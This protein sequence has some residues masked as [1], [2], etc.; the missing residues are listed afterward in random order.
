[1]AIYEVRTL[2][3]EPPVTAL[4]QPAR[5]QLSGLVATPTTQE[6]EH[7]AWGTDVP[8][9]IAVTAAVA[10][11]P[12]WQVTV[13]G[14][15]TTPV[16]RSPEGLASFTV[17]PGRHHLDLRFTHTS[18][19]PVGTALTILGIVTVLV[20]VSGDGGARRRAGVRAQPEVIGSGHTQFPRSEGPDTTRLRS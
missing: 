16:R 1:V 19:D 12:G 7:L 20:A 15:H 17:P 11:D 14:D 13:D 6:P 18:P 9:A 10:F 2:A 4:L 5:P 3:G 8:A